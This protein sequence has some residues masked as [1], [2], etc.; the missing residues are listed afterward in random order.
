[1]RLQIIW[2]LI[3]PNQL[4]TK[5]TYLNS[6]FPIDHH[7]A[8]NQS[9]IA[10]S[11][12]TEFFP[13]DTYYSI[14]LIKDAGRCSLIQSRNLIL[15]LQN[16]I[17]KYG[18]IMTR[19]TVAQMKPMLMLLDVG[20]TIMAVRDGLVILRAPNT[21]T[22]RLTKTTN[23][24]MALPIIKRWLQLNEV[25]E[26]NIWDAIYISKDMNIYEFSNLRVI[27]WLSN[28]ECFITDATRVRRYEWITL[29]DLLLELNPGK[30]ISCIQNSHISGVLALIGYSTY[31][32]IEE[33]SQTPA[34]WYRD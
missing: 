15:K 11:V 6:N 31:I 28:A 17:N 32:D 13:Y 5:P 9:G 4:A 20:F 21:I 8:S 22:P 25:L 26:Q 10:L 12:H 27:H 24:L 1:M 2:H 18:N 7:E 29:V 19:H 3:M 14:H 30:V 16:V 33:N 23:R 34:V